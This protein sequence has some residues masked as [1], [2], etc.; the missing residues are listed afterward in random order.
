MSGV[1]TLCA[2]AHY[3]AALFD[4][5]LDVMKASVM[6]RHPENFW[7]LEEKMGIKFSESHILVLH[8]SLCLFKQTLDKRC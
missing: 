5:L 3:R 4:I 7:F 1:G 2:I 6:Q 8:F